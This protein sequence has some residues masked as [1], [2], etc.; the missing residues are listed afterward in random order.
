MPQLDR[1]LVKARAARL[2]EAA[3][4]GRQRWLDSLVGS[5]QPVLMENG[6]KGH[7]D[8]F[9]PVRIAASGRGDL[10]RARITAR[11]GDHL[12]GARA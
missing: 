1:E 3:R 4:K 11:D 6:G 8:S 9:A 5:V 10:I 2:R 12:V 7:S